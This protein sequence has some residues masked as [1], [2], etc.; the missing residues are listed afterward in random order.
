MEK[1]T[2]P[3]KQQLK[4]NKTHLG[5]TSHNHLMKDDEKKLKKKWKK[6]ET[7]KQR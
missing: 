2:F 7:N 4:Q 5:S 1:K 6:K 3:R